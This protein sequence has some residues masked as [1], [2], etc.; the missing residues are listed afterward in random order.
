[1][2]LLMENAR[3]PSNF[4]CGY[5]TDLNSAHRMI[6]FF[7]NRTTSSSS[8]WAVSLWYCRRFCILNR[9]R[10]VLFWIRNTTFFYFV[11][12]NTD[13]KKKR[14][15]FRIFLWFFLWNV[16]G[17]IQILF[18]ISYVSFTHNLFY[19]FY[20]VFMFLCGW[21]VCQHI[22]LYRITFTSIGW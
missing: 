7:I 19:S 6:W 4:I 1:M 14:S 17:W 9:S 16:P 5:I 10:L 11:L 18:P 3:L 8:C 20:M 12:I 13:I 21:M 22:L 2:K 15:C